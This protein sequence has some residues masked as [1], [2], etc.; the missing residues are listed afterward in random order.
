MAVMFLT[1]CITPYHP[2]NFTGTG[3][4]E[5]NI[6]G[7]TYVVYFQANGLTRPDTV[8]KYLLY[9]CAEFTL[10]EKG[11]DYFQ[12]IESQDMS[13][14]VSSGCC[15]LGGSTTYPGFSKTIKIF[16]GQKT[17]EQTNVYEAKTVIKNLESFMRKKRSHFGSPVMDILENI[18]R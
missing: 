5:V 8:S 12:I 10:I 7:D 17:S 1:A 3:F 9:R 4:E 6:D 13:R 18:M 11:F 15:C 2:K 14:V 16:K